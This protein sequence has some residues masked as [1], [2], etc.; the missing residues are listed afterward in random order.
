MVERCFTNWQGQTVST[1]RRGCKLRQSYSPVI[2]ARLGRVKG[3]DKTGE[4]SDKR[5][6]LKYHA[7]IPFM[8]R[9]T[10]ANGNH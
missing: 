3:W 10:H 1:R 8:L 6:C 5:S 4:A 9:T 7:V 2:P